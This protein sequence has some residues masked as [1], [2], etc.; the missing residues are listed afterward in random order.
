M[1]KNLSPITLRDTMVL[2]ISTAFS[3]TKVL[4]HTDLPYYFDLVNKYWWRWYADLYGFYY[5]RVKRTYSLWLTMA[6]KK[7]IGV[8]MHFY[9]LTPNKRS[10]I[11]EKWKRRAYLYKNSLINRITNNEYSKNF[12]YLNFE[13]SSNFWLSDIAKYIISWK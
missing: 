4:L 3:F 7:N 5:H 13:H 11:L 8:Y 10:K 9:M 6:L 2:K 1:I 12:K